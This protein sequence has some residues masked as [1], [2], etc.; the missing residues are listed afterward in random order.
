M[1]NG[2]PWHE[3]ELG[4]IAEE[5]FEKFRR[6]INYQIAN[7]GWVD[8]TRSDHGPGR[9]N[10]RKY[11]TDKALGVEMSS[12]QVTIMASRMEGMEIDFIDGYEVIGRVAFVGWDRLPRSPKE[13]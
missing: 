3:Q 4:I 10:E 11:Q 2:K 12:K 5:F 8:R 9:D 6:H 13:A 1:A 7:Y